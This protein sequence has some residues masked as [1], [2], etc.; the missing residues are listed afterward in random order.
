MNRAT[1][2][3]A[4]IDHLQTVLYEVKQAFRE[5]VLLSFDL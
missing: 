2:F 5:Q 1:A 4:D 3:Q